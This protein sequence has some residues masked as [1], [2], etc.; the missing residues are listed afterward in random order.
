MLDQIFNNK[1]KCR[2]F[3]GQSSMG[4]VGVGVGDTVK[5]RVRVRV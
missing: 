2:I 4:K 5:V 1:K 3:S